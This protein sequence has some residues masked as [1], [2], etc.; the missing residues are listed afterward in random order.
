[1]GDCTSISVLREQKATRK[2]RWG[3][4]LKLSLSVGLIGLVL[5]TVNFRELVN[6]LSDV[7]VWYLVPVIVLLH[8][9]RGLM[10]YKWNR[11]LQAVD[12]DVRFGILFRTYLVAPLCGLLL[13]STIGGDVFR[14]YSLAKA[15]ANTKAVLASIMV[16]RLIGLAACLLLA[17][18]SLG[19]GWY[20]IEGVRAHVGGVGWALLFAVV[21]AGGVLSVMHSGVRGWIDK[22]AGRFAGG[23]MVRKFH[24][25]YTLS[26]EYRNHLRTVSIVGVWTLVE[27][28]SPIVG[29]SL[30]VYALGIKV[31]LL[32]LV[33][34]IPLIVLATRIPISINGLGVQEGLYI[35]LF[36]LVGVSAAQ[37]FLLSVLG[38]ILGLVS[39]LPWGIHFIMTAYQ[40]VAEHQPGRIAKAQ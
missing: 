30:M 28:M 1:M 11:L 5:S 8:L 10:A 3:F 20:W 25:V 38:R 33:V 27:Q 32:Q 2:R 37:A 6:L 7:N 34:I 35:A 18:V 24:E 26:Y 19:L 40:M 17:F 22:L 16:E 29:N 15:K 23:S 14:L 31:S 13:P 36:G 39:A 9:D 12:V 4:I 21:T